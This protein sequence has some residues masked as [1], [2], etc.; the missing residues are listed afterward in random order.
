MY[1]YLMVLG[2]TMKQMN[3]IIANDIHNG[4]SVNYSSKG[5]RFIHGM[6]FMVDVLI[7]FINS[8]SLG[9]VSMPIF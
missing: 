5:P 7:S 9:G 4:S 6:F 8:I 1:S 3:H 2:I